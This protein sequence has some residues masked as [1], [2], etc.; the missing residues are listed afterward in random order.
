MIVRYLMT[1]TSPGKICVC[2]CAVV[3]K[4]IR[5][6]HRWLGYKESYKNTGCFSDFFDCDYRERQVLWVALRI[7]MG[8][9]GARTCVGELVG[10]MEKLCGNI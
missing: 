9:G 8:R 1:S 7:A 10:S 4:N 6:Q 5:T 3:R 2:L